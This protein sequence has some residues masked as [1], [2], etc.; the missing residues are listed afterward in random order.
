MDTSEDKEGIGLRLEREASGAGMHPL[1]TVKEHPH[2]AEAILA[3][4]Q[5]HAEH[6]WQK[7][8]GV[9]NEAKRKLDSCFREEKRIKS[10]LNRERAKKDREVL[11]AK[12][13]KRDVE[14]AERT[15]R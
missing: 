6:P 12:I 9:C 13:R 8:V 3:L 14:Q 11:L 4:Q 10:A 5:C 1:L 2:C 15:Q 7:F